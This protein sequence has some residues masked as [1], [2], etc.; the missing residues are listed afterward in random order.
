M[1]STLKI[2]IKIVLLFFVFIL[3]SCSKSKIHIND[4]LIKEISSIDKSNKGDLT[5]SYIPE[6]ATLL[7]YLKLEN[8][9]M[10]CINALE[11]QDIYSNY[12]K[13]NYKTFYDFLY[14]ALNQKINLKI[15][16][17]TKYET[18]IFSLDSKIIQV[19]NHH[20]EKQYLKKVDEETFYFYPK[21]NALNQVQ[22]ILYKMYLDNYLISFDDYTG[23]YVITKFK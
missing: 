2:N 3:N 15:N 8:N 17:I 16:Q 4:T 9:K 21:D 20:V 1:K 18:I 22:T 14:D 12:Y 5:L 10:L 11:L 6:K 7:L 23:K 13:N 19:S